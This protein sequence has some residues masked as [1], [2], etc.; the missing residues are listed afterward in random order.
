MKETRRSFERKLQYSLFF[1][2]F[3]AAALFQQPAYAVTAMSNYCIMPPYVKR[4][5]KPNILII[6]DN[7]KSMGAAAYTTSY[8]MTT[9]YNGYFKPGLKY[10]FSSNKW[11][12]DSSGKYSGNLLNWV[13]T[14][15]YDLL[16]SIL[17][18]GISASRQTNI[19]VLVSVS[20]SWTQILTYTDSLGQ[21]RT[22]YFYVNSANVNISDDPNNPG[23]CGYLDTPTPYPIPG[24]PQVSSIQDSAGFPHYGFVPAG[25]E[26]DET[27]FR[28]IAAKVF[29]LIAKA[30]DLTASD[31]EADN[32]CSGQSKVTITPGSP[33]AATLCKSFTYT[34]SAGG[35]N[36]SP[37]PGYVWSVSS[38][39]LPPGLSLS[40]S[41]TPASA[42]ISGSPT[43]DSACSSYPCN[44][45][46]TLHVYDQCGDVNNHNDSKTYTLTVN[47]DLSIT[48]TSPLPDAT[49]TVWMRQTLSATSSCTGDT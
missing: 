33:S 49:N 34:A 26:K 28:S 6:M 11:I 44:Y 9:T 22:C 13:T 1:I 21:A 18:G 16:E 38:G 7:A 4:D 24:D 2:I 32:P 42:V 43:Y 3:C 36:T 12:P 19:N 41:G 47:S 29:G 10:S 17:V 30:M 40:T 39:S 35:G 37:A 20:T 5:I 25:R 48:T 23:S 8:D 46:F 31:A 14:S 27:F 15:R 45:T